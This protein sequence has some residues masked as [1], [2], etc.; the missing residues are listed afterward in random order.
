M[1]V[2]LTEYRAK[3][4]LLGDSYRGISIR[5]GKEKI[6]A[7]RFVAKVDQGVQKRMKQGLLVVDVDA[8]QNTKQYFSLF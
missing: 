8:G 7:G 3:K 5:D 2:K 6:P 1:R 4:I